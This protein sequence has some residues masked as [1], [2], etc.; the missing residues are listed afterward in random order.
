VFEF[1]R[2]PQARVEGLVGLVVAV[3][4]A[5]EEGAAVL[6]QDHR[7]IAIPRHTDGLDQPLLAKVPEVARAWISRAIV[8]VPEITTG[9]HSKRANGR[10]R[11]GLR[12]A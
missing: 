5:L 3:S 1:P 4:M 7:M 10:Q 9:D 12:A 11:A 6:R 2:A 8:V